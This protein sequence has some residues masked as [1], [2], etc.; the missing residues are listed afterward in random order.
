MLQRIRGSQDITVRAEDVSFRPLVEELKDDFFT[1]FAHGKLV[2]VQHPPPQVI[3][4]TQWT[5]PF[6]NIPT[7][8]NF[9]YK[10]QEKIMP[11]P[12]IVGPRYSRPHSYGSEEYSKLPRPFSPMIEENKAKK[13]NSKIKKFQKK[14][15]QKDT[16][17]G[18]SN[19]S[20]FTK[21]HAPKV[22]GD[23]RPNSHDEKKIELQNEKFLT[24]PFNVNSEIITGSQTS[25]H[26]KVNGSS[27]FLDK[28]K[29]EASQPK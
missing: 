21:D 9:N 15:K 5:N 17:R 25:V 27:G 1:G 29:K 23:P 24:T 28:I 18:R 20:Q 14:K 19:S 22:M 4:T 7:S 13:T 12:D 10:K 11:P 26:A 3:Q 8:F 2:Q 16:E 6:M